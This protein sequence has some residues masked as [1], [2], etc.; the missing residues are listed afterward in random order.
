MTGP[1]SRHPSAPKGPFWHPSRATGRLL[2]AVLVGLLAA[3][4]LPRSVPWHLRGVVAWDVSAATLLGV[5]W[6]F[7]WTADCTETRARAATEDAGRAAVWALALASSA[8]SLF[9]AI[10]VLRNLRSFGFQASLFW[11]SLAVIAIVLSWLLTHTSYTLRYAHLYYRGDSESG[12]DFPGKEAPSE[13]DFAYFAFTV[14][15]TFQVS[16]ATISD[17]GIR[18][19]VLG[20]ALLSFVYN[21]IVVGLVLN[22]L[23]SVLN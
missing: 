20:H 23:F 7:I 5:A 3:F 21:T 22:L 14:G 1:V 19:A 11:G 2:L 18:R 6:S 8:F 15:M 10:F 12:I 17:Q 9:A 16:D 13:I 4:L